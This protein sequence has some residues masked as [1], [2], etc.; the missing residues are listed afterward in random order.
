MLEKTSRGRR[1]KEGGYERVRIGLILMWCMGLGSGQQECRGCWKNINVRV[2]FD[3]VSGN[4]G[5]STGIIVSSLV[6][7]LT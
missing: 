4:G 2:D 7:H 3:V 1:K 6:T 5:R